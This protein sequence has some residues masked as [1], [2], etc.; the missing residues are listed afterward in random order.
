MKTLY[1]VSVAFEFPVMAEDEEEAVS[2]I[3]VASEDVMKA[4]ASR[5]DLN[6]KLPDYSPD[7]LVYGT[8]D[9]TFAE[10]VEKEKRLAEMDSKQTKFPW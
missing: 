8:S 10:A 7:G 9:V 5:F 3:E 4:S 1:I 2:Y 6:Q